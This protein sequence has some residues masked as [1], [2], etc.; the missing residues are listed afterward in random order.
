M[1]KELIDTNPILKLSFDFSLM[2][3]D[4]TEHLE[5]LKRFNLANQLF[6]SGTSIGANAMEAQNAESKADFIHKMKIS[7]KECEETQY[8]LFLCKYA[9]NYPDCDLL[10]LKLEEISKIL[11]KILQSSKKNNPVS[12]VWA[13]ISYFTLN[14]LLHK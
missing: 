4:Y 10:I 14:V 13:F 8:L 9:K 11:S 5:L 2:I 6:R 7:A 1:K 12:F 3:I